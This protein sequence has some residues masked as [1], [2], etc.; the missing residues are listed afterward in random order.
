MRSIIT[1]TVTDFVV[2]A[3]SVRIATTGIVG[4]DAARSLCSRYLCALAPAAN[5]NAKHAGHKPGTLEGEH[6]PERGL[7]FSRGGSWGWQSPSRQ[8]PQARRRSMPGFRPMSM[9]PISAA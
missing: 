8:L 3:D 7:S 6:R 1:T 9:Q 5:A 4:V 2:V